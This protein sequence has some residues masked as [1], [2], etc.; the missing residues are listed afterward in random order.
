MGEPVARV[1]KA[2]FYHTSG[3][4]TVSQYQFG[5]GQHVGT[6]VAVSLDR[7]RVW[8]TENGKAVKEVSVER[9]TEICAEIGMPF[10]SKDS[11]KGEW[12]R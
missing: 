10:P 8:Q 12:K 1:S 3:T 6:G 7:K 2:Y 4:I 5:T 11:Q 9:A